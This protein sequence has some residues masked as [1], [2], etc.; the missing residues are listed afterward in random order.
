[1]LEGILEGQMNPHF[2]PL[3]TMKNLGA[4]IEV[5]AGTPTDGPHER[6]LGTVR[7]RSTPNPH[8]VT[9]ALAFRFEEEG[10][11]VVYAGDVG[12]TDDGLPEQ[13]RALYAGADLLIHDATYSPEDQLLRRA[14]GYSSCFD[15][16]SAAIAS[17]VKRLALFHYDQ[18]Y[19]DDFVDGLV[20][21]TRQ[22]LDE[23]GGKEIELIASCEGLTVEV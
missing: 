23:R 22:F 2:S 16:A 12:Y 5:I 10:R 3:H 8:G 7:V 20:A 18:D 6:Q 11:S 9:T 15:A 21:R 14:R 17:G 4:T 13:T 1:M 19:T